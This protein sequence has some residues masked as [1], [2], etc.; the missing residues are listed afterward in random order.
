MHLILRKQWQNCPRE[1]RNVVVRAFV[2]HKEPCVDFDLQTM[3][4]RSYPPQQSSPPHHE[5]CLLF[6]HTA[7]VP[8][9]L[10][11][12]NSTLGSCVCC[13]MLR[14]ALHLDFQTDMAVQNNVLIG[15]QDQ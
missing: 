8:A 14:Q 1:E 6:C 15:W 9:S 10:S 13:L 7:A 12:Q 5:H 3:A 11:V 2:P 4:C